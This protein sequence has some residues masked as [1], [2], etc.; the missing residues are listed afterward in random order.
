LMGTPES[1][2]HKQRSEKSSQVTSKQSVIERFTQLSPPIYM[3]LC[4]KHGIM[5]CL[6]CNTKD[7]CT[8]VN[9]RKRDIGWEECMFGRV[10]AKTSGCMRYCVF[11]KLT[12]YPAFWKRLNKLFPYL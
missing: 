3:R 1:A 2:Y 11:S 5:A 9:S 10:C 4:I 7:E 6:H 12:G 8:I